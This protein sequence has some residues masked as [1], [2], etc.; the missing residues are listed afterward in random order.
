MLAQW[1]AHGQTW[2]SNTRLKS[3]ARHHSRNLSAVVLQTGAASHGR[4][5]AAAPAAQQLAQGSQSRRRRSP[6][7][8][9]CA[10]T[11][12][13]A[14]TE[15]VNGTHVAWQL[16]AGRAPGTA[17]NSVHPSSTSR[18]AMCCPN[19]RSGS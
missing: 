9:E 5:G 14:T 13:A 4:A 17:K 16:Q 7:M 10:S 6:D 8:V 12:L 2:S 3:P 1:G 15:H 11:I 18:E 19:V